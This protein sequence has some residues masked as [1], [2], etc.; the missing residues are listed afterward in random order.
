MAALN[1]RIEDMTKEDLLTI[2]SIGEVAAN[3]ILNARDQNGGK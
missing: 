1:R 2:R 3:A